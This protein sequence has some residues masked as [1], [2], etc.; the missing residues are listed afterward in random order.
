[1][2][3]IKLSLLTTLLAV[4]VFFAQA[5]INIP[6]PPPPSDE[7]GG[8]TGTGTPSSPIDQ[9]GYLLL[10]VGIFLILFQYFKPIYYKKENKF[11]S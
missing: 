5:Q 1:M 9:W 8:T 11:N 2:T 4:T 10:A 6:P 7:G 3:K